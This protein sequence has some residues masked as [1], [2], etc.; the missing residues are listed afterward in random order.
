MAKT[1]WS[2]EEFRRKLDSGEVFVNAKNKL[3]TNSGLFDDKA[4]TEAISDETIRDASV[5]L[6]K[7]LDDIKNGDAIFI[8]L[9]VPSSKN[10]YRI[11]VIFMKA[12][13]CCKA[14]FREIGKFDKVLCTKCNNQVRRPIYEK[15]IDGPNVKKYKNATYGVWERERNKFLKKLKQHKQPYLIG[16]YFIR[17]S[18]R[19]FDYLNPAQLVQDVMVAGGKSDKKQRPQ[20]WLTDDHSKIMKPLFLGEHADSSMPGVIIKIMP[21]ELKSII[22]SYI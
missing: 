16:M 2:A 22:D 5:K 12:T 7:L 10:S 11:S 13:K 19:I 9:N 14:P 21:E 18:K 15:L 3:A 1:T 17:D 8:P 4:M 6:N 20:K